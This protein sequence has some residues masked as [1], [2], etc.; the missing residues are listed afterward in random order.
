MLQFSDVTLA[1]VSRHFGR[2]RAVSHVSLAL[3]AGDVVGLLGPNG[4]GKSTLIGM[5]ATLVA[6]TSGEVRY[7]GRP[8]QALDVVLRTRIGLLAHELYLYPELTA[9]QNLAFFASLY[10]LDAGRV[11]AEGAPHEV[12]TTEHV[13]RVYG[14]RVTVINDSGHRAPIVVPVAVDTSEAGR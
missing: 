2:R 4:A 1:D 7:G 6:P 12:V 14:T 11:V 3:R 5:L 9:S 13:Q 10:G 8:A